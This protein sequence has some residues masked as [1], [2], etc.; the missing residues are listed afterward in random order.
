LKNENI[1]P[2]LAGKLESSS[3]EEI[4]TWAIE[5]YKPNLAVS[6]SFQMQS[7]PLLHMIATL[8]P[9]LPIIFLDTGYHFPETLLFRDQI[10]ELWELNLRV[11]RG[12][13]SPL[14]QTK[15]YGP[16]LHRTDPDFCCHINKVEPMQ[17]LLHDFEGWIS[18]I[19]RDQ[20]P[21]RA[22]IPVIEETTDGV[23]RI[24]PL[25]AWTRADI[26]RYIHRHNLPIHP[27]FSKGYFSIGCAP[28]TRPLISDENE[29]DGRWSGSQKNE[30][31][32]HIQLRP[33]SHLIDSQ[34]DQ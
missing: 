25:A 24:H 31:G 28:C 29:R 17:R 6:S 1:V 34:P 32:L 8:M 3:P 13:S 30:C 19:R 20:S 33:Q 12:L 4:I 11:V 27:L 10:V 23:M 16:E 15:H 5:R 9:D 14:E 7:L 18:G 22:S 26:W 2:S 21:A